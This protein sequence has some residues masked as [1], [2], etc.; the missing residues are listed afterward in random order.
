MRPFEFI[1][2]L[3]SFI[4]TLGLTHLL[5]AAT[6]M[7][8]HRSIV[9]FSWPHALWMAAALFLMAGN[10]ISLWDF[11]TLQTI[12]LTTIAGGFGLVIM[13]YVV[14][15]LVAPELETNDDFDLRAFHEREGRTYIGA[16]LI[17]ILFSFII[18]AA[19]GASLG[20]QNWANQNW[21]VLAMLPA[22]VVPLLT[23]NR[24]VQVLAPLLMLAIQISYP[25][26]YYP[27]LK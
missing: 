6:R 11:H 8:R 2:L 27:V 23:R 12:S 19:A 7:I 18:N 1:I 22:A 3:F 20:I 16:F 24:V 13:E 25:I 21:I 26:I 9:V 10:W 4:Y 5:F 17:I 15:A 14:C